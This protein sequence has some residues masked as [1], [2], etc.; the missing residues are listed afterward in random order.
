MTGIEALK[1]QPLFSWI[2]QSPLE[3]LIAT[4][5][6]RPL[7]DKEILYRRKTPGDAI[8]LILE[9]CIEFIPETGTSSTLQNGEMFGE[10][11]IIEIKE[12]PCEA[13]AQGEAKVLELTHQ[14]IYQFSQKFPDPY[15]IVVT[16]LARCMAARIRNLNEQKVSTGGTAP[17]PQQKTKDPS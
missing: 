10:C 8:Y 4:A 6:T 3:S 13:R 5:S 2:S 1:K 15:S 12:R 14:T 9:G 16:N 11:S 17:E 7:K